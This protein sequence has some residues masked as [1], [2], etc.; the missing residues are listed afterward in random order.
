MA[1]SMMIRILLLE[2]DQNRRQNLREVF[3][4]VGSQILIRW[5]STTEEAKYLLSSAKEQGRPFQIVIGSTAEYNEL[6]QNPFFPLFAEKAEDPMELL[7]TIQSL[8]G[9]S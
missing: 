4:K 3:T 5:A 8:T 7:E 2:D 1:T 9:V 6:I